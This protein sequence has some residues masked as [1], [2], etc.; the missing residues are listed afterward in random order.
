[1]PTTKA[2]VTL[3]TKKH[4]ASNSLDDYALII[5]GERGI[6]KSTL[7][8]AIMGG[9]AL[10]CMFETDRTLEVYRQDI[11]YWSQFMG[12]VDEFL[13]GDHAYSGLVADNGA[14]AYQASMEYAC[15]KFGFDH[16]GGQNDYGASWDKC[17]KTFIAPFRKLLSSR[18][19]LVV[20][21]HEQERE[22][23]TRTG[24]SFVRMRPDWQ[25]Q[26]DDFLSAFV[27]NI[28]Y[29]FFDGEDRWLRLV[30]D[31][32]ITA[33]CKIP[34]H[35]QTPKGEQIVNVPM[36]NSLEEG[37]KNLMAAFNNKQK[38]TYADVGSQIGAAPA[39]AT[40]SFKKR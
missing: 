15:E 4:K 16:P 30:G 24:R 38:D 26:A 37:Y 12:V 23:T 21:C 36:G 9:E 14:V 25:K 11:Q 5:Y 39:E 19:G 35:F 32:Y 28:Y 33:K 7:A 34:G 18:Y 20:V 13:R 8:D 31:E 40:T 10:F 2:R 22:I 1:M 27:E 6:G 3:P 29:Y 17:R